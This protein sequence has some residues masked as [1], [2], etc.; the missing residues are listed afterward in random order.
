MFNL[1][2]LAKLEEAVSFLSSM[3]GEMQKEIYDLQK[4]TDKQTALIKEFSLTLPE[5]S[6]ALNTIR[7][8]LNASPNNEVVA[9]VS[10]RKS[11]TAG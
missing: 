10:T 2:R 9:R 3:T 7:M 6:D 11:K 1:K 4:R 5:M 8:K